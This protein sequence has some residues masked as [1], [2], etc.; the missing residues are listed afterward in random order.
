MGVPPINSGTRSTKL[1]LK[2]SVSPTNNFGK[3]VSSKKVD[4]TKKSSKPKKT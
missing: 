4:V 3:L 1:R 2:K